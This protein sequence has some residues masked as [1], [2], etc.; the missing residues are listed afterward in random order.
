M[1]HIWLWRGKEISRFR[2]FRISTIS[3]AGKNF[4][5]VRIENLH[6]QVD[7]NILNSFFTENEIPAIKMKIMTEPISG[8]SKVSEFV[9]DDFEFPGFCVCPI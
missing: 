7:E 1:S 2:I 8:E 4:V 6:A 9:F 5:G 3:G